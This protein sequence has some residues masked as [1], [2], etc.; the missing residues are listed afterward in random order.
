MGDF[1]CE[2]FRGNMFISPDQ[3]YSEEY[4]KMMLIHCMNK[5]LISL[6]WQQT[7]GTF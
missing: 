6:L 7:Q 4:R 2:G 5:Q 3:F 1:H